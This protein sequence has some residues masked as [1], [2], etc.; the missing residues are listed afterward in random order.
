[1]LELQL[2]GPGQARYCDQPLAGF[3]NQ[4]CY[5]L[6]CYLLLNRHHPHHRERLA[7]LFWSEYPT[8][9]SRKY[10]RN[11]LWRLRQALQS[12]GAPA[13][14]YLLISDDSV[15]FLSSSRYWL[16][17]KVF[18][19]TLTDYQDLSGQGLTAEQAAH[20]EEAVDL[21]I[22]DLLEGVYEDWCLYDRERLSLLCLNALSKLMVFHELNGTYERGLTYG[23][24]I[25]ARDH[26]REKVHRQ[27]MR[28]YW[29]LG[30][31][32]AALI[33][34]KR[35]VQILREELGIPPMEE[36]RLLYER[37]VHNQFDPST[38]SGH[39]LTRRSVRHGDPLSMTTKSND[40]VQPLAEHALQKLQRLQ[41][42]TDV[43]SAIQVTKT[44]SPTEVAEPGG[45]VSNSD[46]SYYFGTA[47]SNLN[48][49]A[50]S[51]TQ[52]NLTW[53]DNSSDESDFRIE[54]SPD[55]STDWTEMA[56]VGA[57]EPSYSNT[58]LSCDTTYYY[59]VRAYRDSDGQYS[60]YSNVDHATTQA[61]PQ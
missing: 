26:T 1:M 56:T 22:G 42:I 7:V 19:T 29:L 5:F 44:A 53:Q 10:L 17:V 45:N 23:E 49:T 47:L 46:P 57:D 41:A 28:L 52:I 9:T 35:C 4:R 38:S 59:R 54:R 12:V 3:P 30:D 39:R 15:C 58:G 27:M 6:L 18:E 40:S 51:Q 37:I 31:R 16:D 33:Q 2:F 11:A 61:C 55:G 43:P 50:A 13:D 60:N 20:L 32:N 48:A 36:T 8:T 34:Y 25:L 24:R 14:E 21:Y